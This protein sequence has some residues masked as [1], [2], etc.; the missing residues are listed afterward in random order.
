MKNAKNVTLVLT[1]R[2]GSRK[3]RV[4]A[5]FDTKGPEA[6]F[7]YGR[8]LKLAETTLRSWAVQFRKC[9]ATKAPRKVRAKA[10]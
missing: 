8:R 7:A 10:A 4:H 9:V 5:M 1:H 6:A 3:S 2:E